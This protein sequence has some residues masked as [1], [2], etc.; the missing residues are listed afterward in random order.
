[1]V[2]GN[3]SFLSTGLSLREGWRCAPWFSAWNRNTLVC[4]KDKVVLVVE[5]KTLCELIGWLLVFYVLATSK[6]ILGRI[7]KSDSV[8]SLWLYSAASLGDQGA[9]IMTYYVT[10][11]HFPGTEP[12]SPCPIL[13]MPSAWLGS[14]KHTFISH[15][16][17]LNPSS[18]VSSVI[19]R[20]VWTQFCTPEVV[21]LTHLWP[22]NSR[23][24][25]FALLGP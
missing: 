20:W 21:W 8:H 13:I 12:T 17:D 18:A 15:W 16:F 1:M 10:Q 4:N 23:C 7:P 25:L 6:V 19:W 5:R 24:L 11:S 2:V 14:D 22:P 3:I 9:S